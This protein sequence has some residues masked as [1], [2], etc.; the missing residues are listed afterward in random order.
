MQTHLDFLSY[1]S[2]YRELNDLLLE[3]NNES[4]PLVDAPESRILIGSVSRM[5]LKAMLDEHM[6]GVY[7]HAQQIRDLRDQVVYHKSPEDGE[8]DQL[9]IVSQELS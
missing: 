6:K 3:T 7:D 8:E 1:Q 9:E 2:T 5:T 4:Y